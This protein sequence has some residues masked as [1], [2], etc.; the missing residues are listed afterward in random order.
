MYDTISAKWDIFHLW[1]TKNTKILITSLRDG[2]TAKSR[3]VALEL[4]N[5]GKI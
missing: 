1:C 2:K 5:R 3:Y 4:P